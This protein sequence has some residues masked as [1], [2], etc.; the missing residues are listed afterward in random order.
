MSKAKT[1]SESAG[2]TIDEGIDP[3][4]IL[5]DS[6]LGFKISMNIKGGII[7]SRNGVLCFINSD[8]IARFLKSLDTATDIAISL[9]KLLGAMA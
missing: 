2:K 9:N 8:N 7:L 4:F 6:P 1:K 5:V 3:E